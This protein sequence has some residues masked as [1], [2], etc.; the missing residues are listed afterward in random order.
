MRFDLHVHSVHSG[1][2]DNGVEEL[3]DACVRKGLA[4]VAIMDHNTLQGYR[5][6]LSMQREGIMLIPGVEVSSAQGH[7]LAYNVEE[8]VPPGLEVGETV[9]LIKAQG[10]IAVAAHPYRLW[11]GLG[12]KVVREHH[13]DA[14]EVHNGRSTR[15]HNQMASALAEEMGLPFTAGSDS[16]EM[17]TVGSAYFESARECHSVEDVIREVLSG[18][19][20]TGGRHRSRAETMG[21][22]VK[23]IT[24]WFGRGFRRM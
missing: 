20:S 22:G 1:D 19:G 10:G 2:S 7:I 5:Q 11:S 15:R 9:D 6:A 21:Y 18:E 4:G 14:I 17:R 8:E 12:E 16:H 23:C 13:F 24:E 3:L